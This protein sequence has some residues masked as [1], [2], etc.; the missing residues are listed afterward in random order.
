[1]RRRFAKAA[2]LAALFAASAAYGFL[3]HRNHLFPFRLARHAFQ[4]LSPAMLPHRFHLARRGEAPGSPAAIEELSRLPY[5]AGYRPASGS[6]G[7]R[8]H[9]PALAQAGFNLVTSGHAPVATLMDMGGTVLKTWTADA[10]KAFPG[11]RLSGADVERDRFLRCARLTPDG[12]VLAMFDQ[13]G[14]VRL[15]AASRLVWA[16]PRR[17]HHDLFV[18]PEENIWVLSRQMRPAPDLG[19]DTEIWE[20]FVEELSPDGRLVRRVSLFDAFRRSL[21]APL[22]ARLPPVTDVFHSNSLQVFD[23]SL[24]ARSPLFR[25]GNILISVHEVDVLAILDPDAGRIVW[26]LSGQW[27]AQHSARLLPTGRVLLFDNLGTMRAASRALEVDA[28]T[29]QVVWSFGGRPGEVL[30]SETNG[31]VQRLSGGNTLVVESNFGR[32]VEITPEGRVVWE[33]VNPNR[34]GAK[35]ELV[36]TLYQVE[37]MPRDPS[38]LR[39]AGAPSAPPAAPPR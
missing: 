34:A 33:F 7:V 32:A 25:R 1:M 12:G 19:R 13:I 3:V 24:A 30:L 14:L 38:F 2:G 28:F 23:G 26:A 20:D 35:S 4:A 39:G 11:L 16:Y 29:Q 17:V 18:G 37:R 6:G 15:D 36:A 5:L 9:E 10:K 27:H 22:L 31:Q 21:Y 8:L